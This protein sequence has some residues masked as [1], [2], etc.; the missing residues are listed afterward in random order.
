LEI[1]AGT[2]FAVVSGTMNS[3]PTG[4]RIEFWAKLAATKFSGFD[5]FRHHQAE[6]ARSVYKTP[7]ASLL[8]GIQHRNDFLAMLKQ[9]EQN[10]GEILSIDSP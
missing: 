5:I 1:L 10:G 6:T 8:S 9:S 4:W 2:L 3:R 7:R